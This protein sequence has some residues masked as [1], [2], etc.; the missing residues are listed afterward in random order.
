MVAPET[1]TNETDT[2]RNLFV[3]GENVDGADVILEEESIGML[4]PIEETPSGDVDTDTETN[5]NTS[6]NIASATKPTPLPKSFII[7]CIILFS[8]SFVVS[9]LF[10]YVVT[11]LAQ[12]LH[13][14]THPPVYHRYITSVY[15]FVAFMVR[16]FG[17]AKND[18]EVGYYSGVLA[19]AFFLGQFSSGC[20]QTNTLL[21]QTT[22]P[23]LV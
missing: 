14:H 22:P 2:G 5:D 12:C 6:S 1:H 13:M 16:D 10:P 3:Y 20:V 8:E 4:K 18:S 9:M 19:S 15:R 23:P 17:V 7:I 21:S 11:Q